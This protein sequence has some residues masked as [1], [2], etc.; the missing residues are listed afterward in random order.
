MKPGHWPGERRRR[1]GDAADARDCGLA[2]RF[3]GA[4]VSALRDT[5]GALYSRA[6]LSLI[7]LDLMSSLKSVRP[8]LSLSAR[9]ADLPSTED[10]QRYQDRRFCGSFFGG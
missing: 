9:P 10:D 1:L 4:T 2:C 3:D 5:P 8:A 7:S 6:Q